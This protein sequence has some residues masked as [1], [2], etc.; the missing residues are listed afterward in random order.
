[1]IKFFKL[2]PLVISAMI[3]AGCT[4]APVYERPE[5]PVAPTFPQGAAYEDLM[6]T[7]APLPTWDNFF[8]NV[9]LREVISTALANNR[10]M[11]IAI[12]NVEKAR[13]AYG[14]QRANLMPN[15]GADFSPTGSHTPETMSPLGVG[16][17]SHTY[18]A[19]LASTAWEI[20]LFGRVRSLTE[21]ALQNYLATEEAQYGTQNALIAE[22][23]NVWVNVGAQ[24]ELLR[25]Q[26]ITLKSQQNSFKLIFDSYRLGARSLLDVE[27]ARTTVE[28][29][30]AAVAQYQRSLAQ[31]RNNLELLVGSAVP[32]SLEPTK[33]EDPS[34]YGAIAP[35]GL[36]SEVL[37]NRP[38]IRAAENEL[39]AANA[40]IGAARAN[41]FPRITLTAGIGT[42]SQHLSD[43]FSGGSG[44]W[45]FAPGVTLPIFTGGANISQLRQAEAEQKAK[46]ASYEKAIQNAFAE[47]ANS[48]AAEGT[49]T[50]QCAALRSLVDA[51]Q[52]AY[53]ISYSR[54]KNGLDGFLTVLESQRQMVSA[55][56]NYIVAEQNRLSSN[57]TL[58]KVLGGGSIKSPAPQTSAAEASST[59]VSA[60][61]AES[62][63]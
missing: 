62:V 36:S 53:N 41:F 2:T 56:T 48:L 5:S 14:I 26:E 27:Q 35:K 16:S 51:T 50:R 24:K 4:M 54:Y 15:V 44:L 39:K 21:A 49:M 58:Y 61:Q 40:N 7:T 12:L 59:E 28:T 17:T 31:A 3:A 22:V 52:K 63:Q 43:L 20:D 33:L 6:V 9:K 60:V 1:M 11:R 38:D 8:T 37:L 10:D 55:Q 19:T 18:K 32:E 30:R 29:A 34:T 57:V 46:V 47:V 45:S 23:A 13:A 42:G 25:L